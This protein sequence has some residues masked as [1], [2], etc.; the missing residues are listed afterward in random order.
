MLNKKNII[1]YF[2]PHQ[3]DELLTMGVDI[4][5]TCLLPNKEVH[6]VLCTDGSNSPAR[7]RLYSCK[8]CPIHNKI[9]NYPL[10]KEEFVQARDREFIS[11]CKALGVLPENIHIYEKRAVDGYLSVEHAKEIIKYYVSIY[12][13]DVEVR[14]FAPFKFGSYQH[15]DHYN[16]ALA[17]KTLLKEKIFFEAKF[18]IET[19]HIPKGLKKIIIGLFYNITKEDVSEQIKEKIEKAIQQSYAY[20]NPEEKRYSV[21]YHCVGKMFEYYRKEITSY[22]IKPRIKI[23][24]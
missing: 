3:D 7:Y 16:L 22:C 13:K 11:S 14:T 6:V 24:K 2:A 18:F 15:A 12:G 21:G 19:Y 1:L 10:S 9:H 5:K 8:V 4:S 20:W 23:F 17:A